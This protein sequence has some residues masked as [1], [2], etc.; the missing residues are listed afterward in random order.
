MGYLRQADFIRQ[1]VELTYKVD[2]PYGILMNYQYGLTQSHEWSFGGENL[3]DKLNFITKLRF[4]NLW[5]ANFSVIENLNR[6]D[7]RE[8]RGGPKLFKDNSSIW[9]LQVMTN[10]VK[11]L[12][13]G[14]AHTLLF[15]KDKI[16]KEKD[17]ILSVKWQMNNR[18]SISTQTGYHVGT[19]YQQYVNTVAKALWNG[20]QNKYIVGK[21]DQKTLYMTVRL[22]YYVSP[23]L[24][25]QYYGSP[26][27][28][29][30]KY[31][32]FRSIADASNRNINQRYFPLTVLSETDNN[33]LIDSN[34]NHTGDVGDFTMRKPDFNFQEFRS[35]LVGRWEFSPGSTLYLVW[36]NT[37][38]LYE[39]NY[40]SSI[41]NSFGGISDLKAKNVF[42][43]K[44]NY[45][46]SL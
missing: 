35:N 46:F 24:S 15:S 1:N 30:G 19:N 8:L 22:E 23:E 36:T 29:I 16:S 39:N 20:N 28:S 25:F 40:N 18:L 10:S 13:F 42:M 38:S 11:K 32:N 21:I 5:M 37:R 43:V 9:N 26:Y 34:G 7:T 45:W 44:L 17:Y 41:G 4:K 33:Y 6:F 3:L 14:V 31:D 2:K 12:S 27:A